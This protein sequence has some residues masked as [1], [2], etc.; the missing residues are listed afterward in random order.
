[1]SNAD[2]LGMNFFPIELD[3]Q[4]ALQ[5][6]QAGARLIDVRE[7]HEWATGVAAGAECIRM[8]ELLSDPHAHLGAPEQAGELLLICAV[9]QRSLHAARILRSQG[10]THSVS[11]V[12]GT[13]LWRAEALPMQ[14]ALQDSDFL[15]RYARHLSLP[16][17]GIEGQLRLQQARVLLA[18]AGGLGSPIALYLAAAGV[19]CLLVCDAD[20]VEL[21]NLQRQVIHR[22]SAIGQHKVES[23]RQTLADLNPR[24]QVI[25]VPQHIN[26]SNV[27]ALVSQVDLVIDGGDNFPLR[28]LLSDACV[29]HAK[30]M[31]YGAVERFSGQVS[32]FDAGRQRGIAPCY[33]CLFPEPP[34]AEDAPNCSE[35]GVLGVLP[36][37]IGLLQATEALKLLLGLGEPLIGRLVQFDALSLR[38]REI[39]IR[40][41]PDCRA[42]APGR[43]FAG[44]ETLAR[45]CRA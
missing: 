37:N 9:G 40:P 5:K 18:G 43:A 42:C 15:D 35:A 34:R 17:V 8:G 12:G 14:G 30:P 25:A 19:G 27:D 22:Q 24:V 38:F 4:Q 28:Y 20:V 44:Y 2:G 1:M 10:Y 23:A 39:R 33:R 7:P 3:P 32:V 11:V 31:V 29:H 21:S 36:G 13:Q 6:Q 45:H 41:D 26:A 16:D